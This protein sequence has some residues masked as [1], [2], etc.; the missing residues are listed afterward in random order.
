MDKYENFIQSAEWSVREE[1]AV[2]IFSVDLPQ[3]IVDE[4]NAYIDNTTIPDNVNYAAN[5]AGQLQWVRLIYKKHTVV[6]L[7]Q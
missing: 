7:K 1:P 5:L 3:S 6:Y 2:K 4:V